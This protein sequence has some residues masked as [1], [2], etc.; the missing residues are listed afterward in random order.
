[1]HIVL[2]QEKRFIAGLSFFFPSN[3]K[4]EH[5]YSHGLGSLQFSNGPPVV[6]KLCI[7]MGNTLSGR[8]YSSFVQPDFI[9]F[10]I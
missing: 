6:S 8:F 1:M 3:D 9:S 4:L 2:I 5:N 10:Y 7:Y